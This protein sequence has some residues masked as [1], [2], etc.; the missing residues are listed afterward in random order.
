MTAYA[1]VES[2]L[3]SLHISIEIR[4]YNGRHLDIALRLPGTYFAWEERIKR[5]I[6]EQVAR[7]RVELRLQIKDLSD[8]SAAFDVDIAKAK[9]YYEA[10]RLLKKALKMKSP[11]TWDQIA[12]VSGVIQ[13]QETTE[14]VDTYWSPVESCLNKALVTLNRMRQ[15]EGDFLLKDFLSRLERIDR[16]LT[17]IQRHA[18]ILPSQ[19]GDR[20]RERISQLTRGVVELDQNRLAQE[21]AILVDRTDISEEIVRA[22]SHIVQFRNIIEEAEPAGRKLN[23]LLQELNREFNTMG[24]KIAQADVA[25]IIVD[26]KAEIEK[27]RE[28]VQNI[29]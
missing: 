28:Q 4:S 3:D 19:Y 21:A 8:R 11:I 12:S 20:L 6:A 5:I 23:F 18:A 26:I 7:G 9:G 10:A 1:M 2:N 16:E 22:H 13:P 14:T 29:E 15:Q 25:H 27:L 24:A 17:V